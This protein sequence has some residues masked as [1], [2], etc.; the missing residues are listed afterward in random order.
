MIK[1]QKYIPALAISAAVIVST[2][3]L[4]GCTTIQ[5]QA[6]TKRELESVEKE[7]FVFYYPDGYEKDSLFDQ[8]ENSA[9]YTISEY[10]KGLFADI[11]VEVENDIEPDSKIDQQTCE[12]FAQ[13]LKV[14]EDDEIEQVELVEEGNMTACEITSFITAS[15]RYSEYRVYYQSGGSKLYKVNILYDEEIEDSEKEV[16]VEAMESFEIK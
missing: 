3:F 4:S 14:F 10:S 5:E 11:R 7:A 13:E 1:A 16:L 2:L 15:G 8:T 9:Y 12:N 6:Q